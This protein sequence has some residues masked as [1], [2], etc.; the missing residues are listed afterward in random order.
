VR[1]DGST[2]LP[3]LRDRFRFRFHRGRLAGPTLTVPPRAS[4]PESPRAERR[5]DP[6]FDVESA[7]AECRD[8]R[9]GAGPLCPRSVVLAKMTWISN[10]AM[11]HEYGCHRRDL[12]PGPP[13]RAQTCL[14]AR[15]GAH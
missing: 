9:E 12:S 2:L 11:V 5:S 1:G 8:P 6:S 13:R 7:L 15:A 4:A 14:R 3:T 10:T